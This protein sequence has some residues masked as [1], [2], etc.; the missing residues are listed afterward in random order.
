MTDTPARPLTLGAVALVVLAAVF[1]GWYGISWASASSDDGLA[2]ARERDEVVL[3]GQQHVVNLLHQDYRRYDEIFEQLRAGSI[4]APLT[5]ALSADR[6]ATKKYLNDGK[7]VTTA[8]MRESALTE[9]DVR[10]GKAKMLAIVELTA[11]A[12]DKPPTVSTGRV[13]VELTRTPDGWKLS[14]L[15][16]VRPAP[17]V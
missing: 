5:D 15:D 9:L 13:A 2:F 14:G 6:E 12:G 4:T 8:K 10:A 7:L 11:T 17:A 3:V 1:A 16:A